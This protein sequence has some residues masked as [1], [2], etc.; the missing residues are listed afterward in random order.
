MDKLKE[1]GFYT[2]EDNRA[3]YVTHKTPLWRCELLLTSRCNFKC[4][5]CRGM[6]DEDKGDI[7]WKDAYKILSLW[8]DNGLKNIRFSGG[9]PTLWENLPKLVGVARILGI[10][11][12]AIS[13]NGS[14]PLYL[15]KEL[16]EN[17]VDDFSV[18]LDSCCAST[19]NKMAGG[20]PIWDNIIEN[21]EYISKQVYTTIGVVITEDNDGEVDRIIELADKIGVSDIRLITAAQRTKHLYNISSE[22]E[23]YPILKYRLNNFRNG[24][25]IRGIGEDDNHKCPLVLDDMAVLNNKHYPCII[26][27]REHGKAIGE[28]GPNVRDERLE[29]YMKHDCYKDKICK[30]NCLDVCVDYNNRVRELNKNLS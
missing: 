27:M 9:E 13:T 28:I 26:Y 18:S 19:G 15:Y 30:N 11:R 3:K 1:I 21:L 29:W 22:L 2:L 14:A 6:K 20:I 17:G 23:K 24:R 4:P 8:I 7:S 16:I 25:P 12:I 10:E 5:Y